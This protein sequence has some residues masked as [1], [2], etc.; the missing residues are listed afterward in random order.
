[1]KRNKKIKQCEYQ[2]PNICQGTADTQIALRLGAVSIS[3]YWACQP[4]GQIV[5]RELNLKESK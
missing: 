4:C 5:K 1:M 3:K 2:L